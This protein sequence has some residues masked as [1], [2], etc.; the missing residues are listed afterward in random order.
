MY[1]LRG[2]GGI[3]L[4]SKWDAVKGLPNVLRQRALVKRQVSVVHLWKLMDK[5][6]GV[7]RI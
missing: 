5:S 1:A 7:S 2:R 3:I 6:L 4:R